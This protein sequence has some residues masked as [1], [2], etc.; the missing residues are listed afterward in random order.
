MTE[1]L[2]VEDD[3]AYALARELAHRSGTT[4]DEAVISSLRASLGTAAPEPAEPPPLVPVRIPSL[5]EMT[6]EQRD[7][8]EHLRILAEEAAAYMGPGATSDHRDMYDEF[9]L[10]K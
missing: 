3:E 6:L 4:V 5:D 10:P 9:G 8:Y 2:I 7:I 1:R